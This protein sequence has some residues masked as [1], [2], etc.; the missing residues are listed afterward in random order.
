M[1]ISYLLLVGAIALV[2][3][4][5]QNQMKSKFRKYGL[6]PL[7]NGMTGREVAATM[8]DHYGIHD[9]NIVQGEGFLSD[10]Y[11]PS[12]KT[13]NLSPDVYNGRSIA[14]ASVAAH[15]CGHVVQH[16]TGYSM[17][18]LRNAI[19]PVVKISAVVQQWGFLAAMMFMGSFPQLLLIVILAM[20]VTTLFSLIT[21]PVEFDAS[22]RALVWLDDTGMTRGTEYDYAKDSLKWAALTYLVAAL[23]SVAMLVYFILSYLGRR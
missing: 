2:G 20:V 23:A 3:F 10:H 9:V 6:I 17:L 11:N 4:L 12:T 1:N 5:V 16:N 7:Q 15:E 8:L 18:A 13:V 19:V 21:L 14:A 22:R